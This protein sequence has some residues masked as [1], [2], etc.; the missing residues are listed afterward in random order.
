[1]PIDHGPMLKP[2]TEVLSQVWPYLV[3]AWV[4]PDKLARRKP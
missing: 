1:M 4:H 2:F 3:N